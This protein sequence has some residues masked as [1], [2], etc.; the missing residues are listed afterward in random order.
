MWWM[1]REW[2]ETREAR[3]PFPKDEPFVNE[4]C[5]PR[6]QYT[7]GGKIK[8][9]TKDEMRK[10]GV[11]SPDL[12]DALMLTFGSAGITMH[13]GARWSAKRRVAVNT[14]WVV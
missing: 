14:G 2:F 8:I 11:H 13:Q 7:S 6:Y 4:I 3:L 12:A 1:M 10:R 5:T 9:E